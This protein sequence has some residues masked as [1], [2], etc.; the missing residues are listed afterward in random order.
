MMLVWLLG[1]LLCSLCTN[2]SSEEVLGE[3]LLG[4]D[5]AG[6]AHHSMC[7]L[8][9]APSVIPEAGRGVISGR[10]YDEGHILEDQV[11]TLK[12]ST[13]ISGACQLNNYVFSSNDESYSMIIFGPGSLYNHQSLQTIQHYWQDHDVMDPAEISLSPYSDYTRNYF[14]MLKSVE[15]GEEIFEYYGDDWFDRFVED[16][17]NS[18]G[19]N[20]NGDD[21]RTPS[22]NI[23]TQ[24]ATNDD[25]STANAANQAVGKS[26]TIVAASNASTWVLPDAER[27][28]NEIGHCL[29]DVK[30]APSTILDAGNGL[31]AR[32][33]FEVGEIVTI[34][35]VLTLPRSVLELS[36]YDSMLMNYC[37]EGN[38]HS[39]II[40][41]PLNYA[42]MIN[43]NS[44]GPSNVRMEWYDWPTFSNTTSY[45]AS[46]KL[47]NNG[48]HM[49]SQQEN[50]AAHISDEG[51][52]LISNSLLRTSEKLE[53]LSVEELLESSYAPLDL[54]FV[55]VRPI[56]VDEEIFLDYGAAWQMGWDEYHAELIEVTMRNTNAQ[57][58]R[59]LQ[60][61]AKVNE[62]CSD[63]C[64]AMWA[65]QAAAAEATGEA[66]GEVAA[67]SD[68]AEDPHMHVEEEEQAICNECIDIVKQQLKMREAARRRH[69]QRHR[70]KS[71]EYYVDE[72]GQPLGEEDEAGSYAYG[73]YA[74][75]RYEGEGEGEEEDEYSYMYGYQH[76]SG[77]EGMGPT[78]EYDDEDEENEW[79]LFRHFI[80]A[81][82]DLYPAHWIQAYNQPSH[83]HES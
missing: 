83:Q 67:E 66:A 29:T 25:H 50:S 57:L 35:P 82:P 13:E 20:G 53:L 69:K 33:R 46:A 9:L 77:E 14:Q 78:H 71:H 73:S 64:A 4:S 40:L 42:P 52:T 23:D 1:E 19:Q 62:H 48:A 65:K 45:P 37:I 81:P 7:G 3:L 63:A 72:N 80:A 34:S 5:A 24:R 32:K 61:E 59:E 41:L 18:D 2:V 36:Y 27:L 68:P 8:Y 10:A 75:G 6:S 43:H 28:L 44:F 54:A 38:E 70:R 26:G 51:K 60:R 11:P 74:G 47:S 15:F 12:M 79:V 22:D 39:D 58:R 31:F 55:A 21:I 30:I 49:A 56:E 17:V 76:D 16:E